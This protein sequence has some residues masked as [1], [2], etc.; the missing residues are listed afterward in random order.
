[1]YKEYN[2]NF[3]HNWT[4]ILVLYQGRI[5]RSSGLKLGGINHVKRE[6]LV[7]EGHS[8]GWV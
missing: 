7:T 4:K 2:D 1:M 8:E 6:T 5:S 3:S